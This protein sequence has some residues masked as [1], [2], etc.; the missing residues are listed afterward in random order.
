MII[1][2]NPPA[3]GASLVSVVANGDPLTVYSNVGLSVAVSLP[4][5]LPQYGSTTVYLPAVPTWEAS[6]LAGSGARVWHG[7]GAAP[8]GETLTFRSV[9]GSGVDDSAG[10]VIDGGSA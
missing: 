4:L 8:S 9:L 2:V 3:S 10:Q 6:V 7:R 5:T 1:D